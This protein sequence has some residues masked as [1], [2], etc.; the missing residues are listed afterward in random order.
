MNVNL[1]GCFLTEAELI[2]HRMRSFHRERV[3]RIQKDESHV[4]LSDPYRLVV[5]FIPQEAVSGSRH[6]ASTELKAASQ[7]F[8]RF[9]DVSNYGWRVS[10]YNADGFLFTDN[11]NSAQ[12]YAQF[13]RNG[14]LEAVMARAAFKPSKTDVLFFREDACEDTLIKALAGYLSFSKSL[15]LAL[16]FLLFPALIGCKGA[17]RCTDRR[18]NDVS[19]HAIDRNTVWLSEI[20][21]ETLDTD[22]AK[23]LRS[24]CDALW[25]SVGFEKS[26]SFDEQGNWKPRR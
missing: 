2:L 19:E 5:H 8:P 10:R 21:I 13:H 12:Q 7:S 16:P 25:N 6:F 23:H 18:F 9:D 22:P 3:E 14:I 26:F 1:T 11:Q 24:T 17:K 20:R 4:C 15:K